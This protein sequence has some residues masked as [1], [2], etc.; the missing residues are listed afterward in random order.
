MILS[1]FLF[2]L[3]GLLAILA[4]AG[5]EGTLADVTLASVGNGE[6]PNDD[7]PQEVTLIDPGAHE[8]CG[9]RRWS[10]GSHSVWLPPYV[11]VLSLLIENPAGRQHVFGHPVDLVRL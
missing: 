5:I 2:L 9:P 7:S 11:P 1:K 8:R 10:P 4:L 3:L 6:R